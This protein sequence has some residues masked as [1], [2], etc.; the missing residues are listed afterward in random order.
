MR[1]GPPHVVVQQV[2][3]GGRYVPALAEVVGDAVV[4]VICDG[5]GAWDEGELGAELLA[6]LLLRWLVARPGEPL[7][8]GVIAGLHA[9]G[10]EVGGRLTRD[11]MGWEGAGFGVL[12]A[13]V[14]GRSAEIAS[15]GA[16]AGTRIGADGVVARTSRQT[17]AEASVGVGRQ[18]PARMGHVWTSG[19]RLEPDG[20]IDVRKP[21]A[22]GW[23]LDDG[24]TV[25]LASTRLA[26]RL[27]GVEH[28]S[29][30]EV[31]AVNLRPDA[32]AALPPLERDE[33]RWSERRYSA[34]VVRVGVRP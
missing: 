23:S 5:S 19:V 18:V 2:G 29:V 11:P 12:A 14:V 17:L 1:A 30:R 16:M 25:V 4:A 8:D 6:P 22:T 27:A 9:C 3:E 26:E 34:V 24:D 32:V 33:H 15:I 7:L 13:R 20:R 31:V 21:L 28:R 10:P